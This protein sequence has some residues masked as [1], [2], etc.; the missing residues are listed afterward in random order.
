MPDSRRSTRDR[1]RD[2][3]RFQ[4]RDRSK[5]KDRTSTRRNDR[6]TRSRSR[7]P[8]NDA[9]HGRVRE[10]SPLKGP[11]SNPRDR[12]TKRDKPATRDIDKKTRDISITEGR[13]LSGPGVTPKV[14]DPPKAKAKDEGD[15]DE[16]PETK[17]MRAVMGFAGFKSTKNTKIPGNDIYCVRK[18][19]ISEYR[20][21]MN[22]TGG[23][24][25]PLS[26]GR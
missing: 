20:Q 3:D 21:Y 22:R 11:R 1:R 17:K 2:D 6:H 4:R 16:D 26:P 18:E 8:G 10:R 5:S 25:R 24:N 7:S 9:P 14:T 13:G 12:D 15:V 19:T 23:F